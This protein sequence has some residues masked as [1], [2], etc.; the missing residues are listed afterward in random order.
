MEKEA[1]Q[2]MKRA[3]GADLTIALDEA[4]TLI[5][6]DELATEM[7]SWLNDTPHV[8]LL[9]GGADG[10]T[11]RCKNESDHVWSLSRLTLPHA[12]VRVVLVE[13]LYRA[14]TILQGHPYHRP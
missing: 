11:E 9:I 12:L 14:W 10:L 4:G 3:E 7:K 6:S 8:A 1:A 13:Q 5:S 2:L